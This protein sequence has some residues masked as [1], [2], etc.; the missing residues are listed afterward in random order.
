MRISDWSSDVCSSDLTP[1]THFC[2]FTFALARQGW[3]GRISNCVEARMAANLEILEA[4][5]AE[6]RAGGGEKRVAAHHAKGRLTARERLDVL[7]DEG[8][9]EGYDMFVE[10]NCA[11]FGMETQ[12]FPGDGVVQIGRTHV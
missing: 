12:K 6:A 2:K 8:S 3:K 7:L 11:S 1:Y 4:K 10:H 9:F 5:R